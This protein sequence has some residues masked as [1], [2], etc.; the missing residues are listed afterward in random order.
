[1]DINQMVVIYRE[2]MTFCLLEDPA[3]QSWPPEA[4]VLSLY[5]LLL[6]FSNTEH[7]Q[8]FTKECQDPQFTKM[9]ALSIAGSKYLW[10]NVLKMGLLI[11]Q[12]WPVSQSLIGTSVS[13][14]KKKIGKQYEKFGGGGI[15]NWNIVISGG[16]RGV[17][18]S[19]PCNFNIS[20]VQNLHILAHLKKQFLHHFSALVSQILQ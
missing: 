5:L 1:M 14:V 13:Q 7:Y 19:S 18:Q 15:V 6:W 8:I 9:C 10:S 4:E 20:L 3:L 12:D 17:I 11:P 16:C 2:S